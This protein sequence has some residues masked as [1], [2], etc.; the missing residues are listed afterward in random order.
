MSDVS[1]KAGPRPQEKIALEQKESSRGIPGIS[2]GNGCEM[3]Q[4]NTHTGIWTK[5]TRETKSTGLSQFQLANLQN[6]SHV[7]VLVDSF[8][9]FLQELDRI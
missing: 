7:D 3:W 4:L 6:T 2:E 1:Y 9:F 8:F 5:C